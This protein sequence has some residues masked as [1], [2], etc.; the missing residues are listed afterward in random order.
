MQELHLTCCMTNAN[1]S[2]KKN[3][4]VNGFEPFFD[5]P[6]YE[7]HINRSKIFRNAPYFSSQLLLLKEG[8]SS[9]FTGKHLP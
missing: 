6:Y 5:R 8:A 7:F 9:K 3:W 1:L 2:I 4:R